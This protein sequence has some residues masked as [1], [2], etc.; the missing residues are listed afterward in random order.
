MAKQKPFSEIILRSV[1]GALVCRTALITGSLSDTYKKILATELNNKVLVNQTLLPQYI[2][3]RLKSSYP[4]RLPS[5]I[6]SNPTPVELLA[7]FVERGIALD[8]EGI[9]HT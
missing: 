6:I 9:V 4:V 7:A 2:Y 8:A 3:A 5:Q 1:P